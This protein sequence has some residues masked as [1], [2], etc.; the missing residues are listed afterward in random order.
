MNWT[1]VSSAVKM[2]VTITPDRISDTTE[3]VLRDRARK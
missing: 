3:T 2:P 1:I